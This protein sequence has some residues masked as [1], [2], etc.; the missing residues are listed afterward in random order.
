M[1]RIFTL[2][3][4]CVMLGG[5]LSLPTAHAEEIQDNDFTYVVQSDDTVTITGYTGTSTEVVI[6]SEIEGKAVTVIGSSAL[7]NAGLTSVTIPIGITRIESFAFY[8]NQLTELTIPDGVTYIGDNAFGSNQ[9]SHAAIPPSVAEIYDYAFADNRLG[10]IELPGV[11]YL[12]KG[13]FQKNLL[14]SVTLG[15]LTIL[16]AVPMPSRTISWK[17]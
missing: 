1:R 8:R 16:G 15:N 12:G 14:Q 10:A 17:A 9:L 11:T 5:N 6:P 3:M 13:A 4:L 2:F 7:S